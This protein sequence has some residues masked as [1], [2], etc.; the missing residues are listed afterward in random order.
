MCNISKSLWI[1]FN[2]EIYNYIELR[3]ELGK[4]RY[5]FHT[6]SDS[7]VVLAASSEWGHECVNHFNGMWAFVIYDQDKK[8]LFASRD[9]FGVK[10]FYYC[11][12]ESMFAFA[13]EQKALLSSGVA[14]FNVNDKAIFDYWLFASMEEEEEGMFK[15]I[16]EL[17][18]AHSL[19]LDLL[20]GELKKWKY[21]TFPIRIAMRMLISI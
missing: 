11:K 13:S 16:Y 1:V 3:D 17:F 4:K 21:Y 19:T 5:K 20:T 12:D 14:A 2:G 9:R 10:P 15:G 6:S 18:P 7:E 8:Q